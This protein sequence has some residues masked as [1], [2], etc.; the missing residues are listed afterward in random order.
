M[1]D[2][3]KALLEFT[4]GEDVA[5]Q[6]FWTDEYGE[7]TP[8]VEPVLMDVKDA[9]GQIALRFATTNDPETQAYVAVGGPNGFFQFTA[10]SALTRLLVPGQYEFDLFAAVADSSTF[11]AQLQ[12]VLDGWVVVNKRTTRIEDASSSVLSTDPTGG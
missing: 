1:A 2:E 7:P 10:P 6:F 5:Y 11:P 9:N 8:I 3:V 12:K 4:Q